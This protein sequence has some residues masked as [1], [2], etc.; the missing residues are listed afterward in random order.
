MGKIVNKNKG[1]FVMFG[2]NEILGR[3]FSKK[4]LSEEEKFRILHYVYLLGNFKPA[5]VVFGVVHGQG[6]EFE[7]EIVYEQ[8]QKEELL[9]LFQANA[10]LDSK[11]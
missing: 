7:I 10:N 8:D 1:D 6:D 11:Q 9:K 5:E 2:I 3:A 4:P